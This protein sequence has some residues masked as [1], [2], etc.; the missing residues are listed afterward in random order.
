MSNKRYYWL[1]L[2]ED[3][4]R[5]LE[6]KR[7]RK[8]AGGDTY[9]VIYLK[10]MLMT[11]KTGGLISYQGIYDTLIEE[12]AEEIDEDI[13]N[14]T[15]TCNYLIN[16]GLM[17]EIGEANLSLIKVNSMTGSESS[18]AARVRRFREN[19]QI[20]E[21]LIGENNDKTLLGNADVTQVKRIGNV[22]IEKE[23][24]IEIEIDNKLSLSCQRVFD[25]YNEICTSL[26]KASR[27]SE[28]R[29]KAIR[30]ISKKFSEEEITKVFH[31]AQES[32]FLRGNNGT[33][34]GANI[35]WLMIEGNFLKTLEGN[36]NNRPSGNSFHNFQ[37]R[38]YDF[39]AIT[40]RLQE[41]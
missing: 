5:Q 14:V 28:K 13:D 21:Q 22:E 2:P 12:I 37:E 10:M 6:I 41:G 26:P 1:K 24:E 16:K 8:L 4:F 30:S 39:D 25:L 32:T 7:L 20:N 27:L 19:K 29:K 3:F 17:E 15:V 34:G 36:Y 11:I 31:L 33:W 35:D 23:K 40:R 18:S 38:E 9:T